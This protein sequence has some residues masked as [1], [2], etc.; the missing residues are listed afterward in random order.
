MGIKGLLP[1]LSDITRRVHVSSFNGSIVAVDAFAWLHR[2]VYTCAK[3]ICLGI[4][5]KEYVRWCIKRID[6]LRR[7][8][9]E[10]LL[11]F[12]G[13]RLPLKGTTEQV[14]MS[15]LTILPGNHY[16]PKYLGFL[17]LT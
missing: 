4:H 5:T 15:G 10:P 7:H 13:A 16:P 11:V 2:A 3:D 8:G 1:F 9:V 12:D 6:M 17:P 14:C